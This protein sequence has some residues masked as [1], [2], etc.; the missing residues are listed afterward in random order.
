MN[1]G[2]RVGRAGIP[3]FF[4]LPGN[5]DQQWLGFLTYMSISC[6]ILGW[7]RGKWKTTE[8]ASTRLI[9]SHFPSSQGMWYSAFPISGHVFCVADHNSY[10]IYSLWI[11]LFSCFLFQ[12]A[13]DF[14][15]SNGDPRNSCSLHYIHPY[16]PNEYLKALV[17]VGEICQDYDRYKTSSRLRPYHLCG[18]RWSLADS[19]QKNGSEVQ[20]LPIWGSWRNRIKPCPNIFSSP[21]LRKLSS[22]HAHLGHQKQKILSQLSYLACKTTFHPVKFQNGCCS[23]K[24]GPWTS[25]RD[26]LG[27]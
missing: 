5:V 15:A 9:T 1:W 10:K 24:F 25:S 3:P 26:H 22:C 17:A 18:F 13:I 11:Y 7:G 6:S 2:S 23:S 16:Q 19:W 12:V 14:T 27:T 21:H 4:L 20:Q 8:M